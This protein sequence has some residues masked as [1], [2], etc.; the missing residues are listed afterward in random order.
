MGVAL[1]REKVSVWAR[2]APWVV[3]IA[4]LC[5]GY[6]TGKGVSDFNVT[7]WLFTYDLEF[8]RRAL[9]GT[10]LWGLVEPDP[11]LVRGLGVAL[12]VVCSA[13]LI[14]F[15]GWA[16]RRRPVAFGVGFAALTA[17][18]PAT[19]AQFGYDCGRFDQLNLILFLAALVLIV[20]GTVAA[21][22]GVVLLTVIALLIHEAFVFIHVPVLMGLMIHCSGGR[23]TRGLVLVAVV[24]LIVTTLVIWFGSLEAVDHETYRN[25]L[26]ERYDLS[27]RLVYLSSRVLYREL[28]DNIALATGTLTRRLLNWQSLTILAVLTPWLWVAL[29][30]L[31]SL[32]AGIG[33]GHRRGFWLPVIMAASPLLLIV[34]GTDLFRWVSL[35]ML[36]LFVVTLVL[37]R[38]HSEADMRFHPSWKAL[39]VLVGLGLLAGP[40]GIERPF[41][42][43][44]LVRPFHL[45]ENGELVT[46]TST[47]VRPAIQLVAMR[48]AT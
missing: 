39:T 17:A 44:R 35:S 33:S 30:T 34:V 20:R 42:R 9:V 6:A 29:G 32:H 8:T 10:L 19:L 22:L 16:L 11:E 14:F 15:A 41:P 3:G 18:C 48:D 45:A 1:P 37:V 31:R 2:F 36:N 38:I 5:A 4:A 43:S 13:A 27:E 46:A 7:H 26:V 23:V 28:P 21:P 24:A 47:P 40:I 12:L 25:Q